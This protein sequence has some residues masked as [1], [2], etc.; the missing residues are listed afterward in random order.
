M[1]QWSELSMEGVLQLCVRLMM[2]WYARSDT[3]CACSPVAGDSL[4]FNAQSLGGAVEPQ[5]SSHRPER[6]ATRLCRKSLPTDTTICSCGP[7]S[8]RPPLQVPLSSLSPLQQ[9]LE[10]LQSGGVVFPQL[11]QDFVGVRLGVSMLVL[12]PRFGN[13]APGA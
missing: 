6:N 4:A 9:Q 5:L 3:A 7:T 11:G 8:L 12:V 1:D 13:R 2:K 10:P